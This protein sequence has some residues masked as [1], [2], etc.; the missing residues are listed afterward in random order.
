VAGLARVPARRAAERPHPLIDRGTRIESLSPL[1]CSLEQLRR[2]VRVQR[3]AISDYF[4]LRSINS[5]RYS[6]G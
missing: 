6:S 4:P 5:I 1:E 3:D 2:L